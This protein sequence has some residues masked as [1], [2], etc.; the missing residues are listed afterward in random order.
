MTRRALTVLKNNLFP[1][2]LYIV[3]VPI[4]ILYDYDMADI[5]IHERGLESV[6]PNVTQLPQL[7]I[8]TINYH[9]ISHLMI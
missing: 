3:S 9:F 7:A 2:Y 1:R 4:I 5:G 6:S 8:I